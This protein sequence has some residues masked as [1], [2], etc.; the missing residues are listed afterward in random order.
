MRQRQGFVYITAL[1][2]VLVV[3]G[4]AMLLAGGGGQR[5]RAG[6]GIAARDAARSAALGV[7]RAAVND[8]DT[9]M[10]AGSLPELRSVAPEGE[11]VGDCTVMLIGRDPSGSGTLFGLIPEAGRIDVNNATAARLAALPGCDEAIAA[12]IVDW[13]DADDVPG[14]GG[15]ERGDGAYSGAAVAY[16]PRNAPIETLEELRLVRG[17]TD[18]LWF[19]EDANRNG[20]LDA[21]EDANSNGRLDPGLCD[22]LSLENRESANAPDGTARTPITR[23]GELRNRLIALFGAARGAELATAAQERQPYANRLELIGALGL[24]DGEA[25]SLWPFLIGPEGRVGLIDAASCREDVL[26]AALGSE[27]A[28]HIIAMRPANGAAADPAWLAEA[29]GRE[30][31]RSAGMVLTVGSYRFRADLLAV[32][33]DGS[34]WARLEAVIDCSAGTTRVAGIR[35]IECLGWPLPWA[36]PSRLR[37]AAPRDVAAFL[38]TGQP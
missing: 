30:T 16:A 6:S 25:A 14:D 24:E 11:V 21:S 9:A 28:S 19:G 35:P 2:V 10:A 31:A 26:A 38:A 36:T 7:L 5:L 37:S 4:I 1:L 17:V 22:L 3:A 15:A 23:M 13:R 34:G 27:L 8:L 20:R 18:T 29:L 32:R 12:A 33:N